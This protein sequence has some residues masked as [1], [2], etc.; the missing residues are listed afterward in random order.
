MDL[1]A[2]LGPRPTK[3]YVDKARTKCIAPTPIKVDV[4]PGEVPWPNLVVQAGPVVSTLYVIALLLT[5][6][7]YLT[8][9]ILVS[10]IFPLFL[11]AFE[12][13]A[14]TPCI[15]STVHNEVK[16]GDGCAFVTGA[17]SGIGKD[18]A[19]NLAG[20]GFDLVLT[21]YHE[22][23]GGALAKEM[24]AKN[25]DIR[26]VYFAAD[27]SEPNAA[28]KIYTLFP[29]LPSWCQDVSI[30]VNDAG[31]GYYGAFVNV[32]TE[33]LQKMVQLN[34]N[35]PVGLMSYFLKPMLERKRGL[36]MNLGSI[37]S[38]DPGPSEATYGATKAFLLS[39]SRAMHYELR[40]T[41]V[42]VTA[43]CPGFTQTH[44]WKPGEEPLGAKVPCLLQQASACAAQCVDG[45][46]AR[47]PYVVVGNVGG[48]FN[49]I[50][51]TV[52]QMNT[53][54][55]GNWFVNTLWRI[56]TSQ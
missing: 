1:A 40:S 34:N 52:G 24:K 27:L 39:I 2:P 21:G 13:I 53:E 16:P 26:V 43:A 18:I 49:Q 46:F 51:V 14:R 37:Q 56:P 3:A 4:S 44:F 50:L 47:K 42:S 8:Y 10:F 32:P 6:P 20:R 31:V 9:Y 55:F 23:T 11:Y 17:D 33:K 30:L 22:D 45:M 38:F 28:T 41:G 29:Q 36:V 5:L 25:P 19:L 54:D 48:L 12:A 35:T 7:F 15:S